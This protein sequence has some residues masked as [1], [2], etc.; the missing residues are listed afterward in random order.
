MFKLQ[1]IGR[2]FSRDS[3]LL[4]VVLSSTSVDCITN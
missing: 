3:S 1:R 2:V 4:Q